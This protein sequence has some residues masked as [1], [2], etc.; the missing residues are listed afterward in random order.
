MKIDN[1]TL[2]LALFGLVALAMVVQAIV[3]L[4]T[5][6]AVRKAARS[7]D[8][9]IE[10]M[11]ASVEPLIITS[12]DL[13][14]NL[15]PKITAMT[16]DVAAIAHTLRVQTADLQTAAGEIVERA[17]TQASR[18]DT[19]L[20]NF[21]DAM[22]RAGGFVADTINKPVRQVNA[23][24]ASAKA[25]IESLRTSVPAPRAPGNHVPGDHDM[26]V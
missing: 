21:L 9:K 17:R 10:E 4:A 12:R 15:A 14:T 5:F 11:R 26:F 3:L 22:D 25:V 1:Q 16:E 19:M 13:M 24:I 18:L 6:V 7:M 20:S 2:Q 8:E 23:L